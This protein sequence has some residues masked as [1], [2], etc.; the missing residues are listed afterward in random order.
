MGFAG[1]QSLGVPTA[2]PSLGSHWNG[3]GPAPPLPPADELPAFPA[4]PP[5]L[6]PAAVLVAPELPAA[7]LVPGLPDPLV[8]ELVPALL[9]PALPE[10]LTPPAPELLAPLVPEPLTPLAP[11]PLAPLVPEA[12]VPL[13]FAVTPEWGAPWPL[14]LQANPL[15]AVSSS[16]VAATFRRRRAVGDSN[17]VSNLIIGSVVERAGL[18]DT[19]KALFEDPA[20]LSA[21]DSAT[22][23]AVSW[24]RYR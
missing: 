4:T 15:P 16:A 21:P 23:A 13:V 14:E 24:C 6:E 11:E 7:P 10:P 9:V 19:P 20:R 22:Q 8:P 5:L 3:T 1:L 2:L 17:R 12:P 18:T